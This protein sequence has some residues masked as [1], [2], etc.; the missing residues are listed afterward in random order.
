MKV[1]F[2]PLNVAGCGAET[3]EVA[4]NV[5]LQ[6]PQ[7]R[8]FFCQL[9][10]LCTFERTESMDAPSVSLGMSLGPTLRS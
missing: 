5:V 2:L 9:D 10:Y 8:L 7:W 6:V 3:I 1:A 4:D